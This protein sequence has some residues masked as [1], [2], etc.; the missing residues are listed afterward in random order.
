MRAFV[1]KAVQ[2]GLGSLGLRLGRIAACVEPIMPFDVL[3]LA[4]ESALRRLG[5][6]VFYFI[7]VRANDGILNDFLNPLIRRLELRGCIIEPLP[8]SKIP[9]ENSAVWPQ[10]E[11]RIV[12]FVDSDER[13]IISRNGIDALERAA[14]SRLADEIE[15]GSGLGDTI[16]TLLGSIGRPHVALFYIDTEGSEDAVIQSAFAAGMQPTII[17]YEWTEMP[18]KRR[19]ALKQ[20]L[21]AQGY[22]F[23]DVGSATL[24]VRSD[25]PNG[26]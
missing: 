17:Q 19:C 24:C 13:S 20:I 11:F 14:E 6:D 21:L 15:P 22:R 7:H 10:L 9:R 16:T 2:K 5:P 25:E 8:D 4:I 12:M 26:A 3:E 1:K 23:I 18:L